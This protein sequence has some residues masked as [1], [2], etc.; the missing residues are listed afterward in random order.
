LWDVSAL[1]VLNLERIIENEGSTQTGSLRTGQSASNPQGSCY[2]H[3]LEIQETMKDVFLPK[4]KE[5][6][7]LKALRGE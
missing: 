7:M 6:Q 4:G 1:E 2:N 5:F 3:N